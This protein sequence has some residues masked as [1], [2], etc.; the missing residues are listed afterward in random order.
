MLCAVI[1]TVPPIIIMEFN[2]WMTIFGKVHMHRFQQGFFASVI[3]DGR[4][5]H[6]NSMIFKLVQ[7]VWNSLQACS[8]AVS[9]LCLLNI[10]MY[11]GLF[12]VIAPIIDHTAC[13]RTT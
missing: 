2:S 10:P 6:V 7:Q 5:N 9:V 3:S 13:K 11:F 8:F 1:K 12:W 4:Q